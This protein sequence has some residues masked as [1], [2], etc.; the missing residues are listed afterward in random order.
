MEKKLKVPEPNFKLRQSLY[1]KKKKKDLN[2]QLN[3]WSLLF[4]PKYCF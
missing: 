2:V 1:L 3:F 4:P